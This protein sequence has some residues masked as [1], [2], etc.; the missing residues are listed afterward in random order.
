M[1]RKHFMILTIDPV[2]FFFLSGKLRARQKERLSRRNA[3]EES[4]P[5]ERLA[6]ESAPQIPPGNG[7]DQAEKPLIIDLED[8]NF[9]EPK[10]KDGSPLRL[11][12]VVLSKGSPLD[13]P[14]ADMFLPSHQHNHMNTQFPNNLLPVL[15]LCAPNANQQPD[16]S[17]KK[18]SSR[19]NGRQVRTGL[20][21]DFPFSL[22]PHSATFT[23]T[24]VN[25]DRIANRIKFSDNVSQQHLKSGIQDGCRNLVLFAF[26]CFKFS[27]VALALNPA[28]LLTKPSKEIV[29]IVLITSFFIFRKKCRCRLMRNYCRGSNFHLR[30]GQLHISTFYLA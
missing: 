22:P 28:I 29:L 12:R 8:K 9:D 10:R 17:H 5:T 15:G 21:P 16:S 1:T 27:T 18:A 24:E 30:A 23:D 4:A 3:V 7:G 20:G 14:S 25:A 26:I 13:Y 19:S 2:L 6:L 11:G